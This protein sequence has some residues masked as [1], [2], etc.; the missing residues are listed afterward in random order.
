MRTDLFRSLHL[1]NNGFEV[2]MEITARLLKNK[3][4]IIEAPISYA[5]RPFQEGKKIRARDGIRGLTTLLRI[6]LE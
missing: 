3:K 4:K 1:T 6:V 5:P 2:E